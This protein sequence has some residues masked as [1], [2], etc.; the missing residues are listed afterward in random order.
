MGINW[1]MKRELNWWIQ[2]VHEQYRVISHGNPDIVIQ[3]DASLSGWGF[4]IDSRT[5]GGWWTKD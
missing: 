5:V 2:H 3:T 4:V 1:K